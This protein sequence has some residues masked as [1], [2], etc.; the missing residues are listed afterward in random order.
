MAFRG[1]F[2]KSLW[3]R[4]EAVITFPERTENQFRSGLNCGGTDAMP[5][6]LAEERSE[7]ATGGRGREERT[8]SEAR[9]ERGAGKTRRRSRRCRVESGGAMAESLPPALSLPHAWL[10]LPLIV[11][12]VQTR[13]AAA[14]NISCLIR[15]TCTLTYGHT[16]MLLAWRFVLSH[17]MALCYLFFLF[18]APVPC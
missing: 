14:T 6:T 16:Q 2:L 11:I 12:A 3:K 8:G 15:H 10:L 18:F 7:E 5:A 9:L 4:S 17:F 13:P 1:A